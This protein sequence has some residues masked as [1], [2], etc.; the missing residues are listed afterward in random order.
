M[1]KLILLFTILGFWR[2]CYAQDEPK[3][4]KKSEEIIIRNKGDKKMDMT[5]QINGDSITVNGK[6]LN[7][8]IDS[9]VTIR[10][11][12][13]MI[14]DRDRGDEGFD[15][16]ND[17]GKQMEDMAKQQEE[18][19]M[20]KEN[21]G[22][23]WKK[24]KESSHAF[25]GVTTEKV[26][27]G[28]LKIIEV[29]PG[30]AAEKAGLK[31]GDIIIKIDDK[32][33]DNPEMLS[34]VIMSQKPKD[35]IKVYYKRDGKQKNVKAVLGERKESKTFT[36]SFHNPGMQEFEMPEMPEQP[37]I[38][39]MPEMPEMMPHQKKLG[40]KIQDTDDD[41]VKV[42]EVEDSSA[43][44]KAGIQ[45]NDIITEIDGDKINNTDEARDHLHPEPGKN[46][47]NI[48]VNRNGSEINFDV[49]IPKKLKTADL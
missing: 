20:Q 33:I 48:K 32:K 37:E 1:K 27:N 9:Q 28:D 15:F 10:K 21:F 29:V 17:F 43:A 6:P 3:Q 30:S 7:E 49:K 14:H 2:F 16:N 8:Y 40:I 36:Y 25:L 24:H 45:K 13:M 47:Y 31:E 38:P 4:D 22:R 18:I 5:I 42:I 34:S 26:D 39:E 46:S 12:K 11:R 23:E 44:S 19:A 41:K 35:E